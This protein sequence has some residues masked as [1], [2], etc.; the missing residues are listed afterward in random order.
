MPL[1]PALRQQF[2]LRPDITYLNF[3]SFGACPRPVFEQY[4]QF[5]LALEQ[6]PVQ[7][8][9]ETGPQYLIT[10]REALSAYIN[11]DA[12]DLVYVVNPSHAVNI[13]AKSLVLQPGDEV[14]TTSLEYGACDRTWEFYCS[15][16]GAHYVKQP[17]SLP[18]VSAEDFV[19]QFF[20]GVTS[21]T[22][23]VFL[24]HITSSTALRLP[25]EL[26]IQEAQKR[27]L[28][29]FVDGA[30]AP[31]QI[32]LDLKALG[33]DFYTG[34]CHKWMMTPKGSSFL[35][36]KKEMQSLLEPL[37]VSWGYKSDHP[38]HSA[39]LDYHQ[40]QGTRDFSAFLCIPAALAFMKENHWD[41][42]SAAC[43]ALVRENAPRF[44]ELLNT[45]P[46]APLNDQF[47][48]QLCSFKLPTTD[49]ERVKALLFNQFHIE[50]PVMRHGADVYL[51]YSIQAF[52]SQ[53]D[54]DKLY[55][56]LTAIKDQF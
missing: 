17:I 41:Q 56:A 26:I 50:I 48:L 15:K 22:K 24:S 11:V 2:L 31:G 9:T 51:R 25:V 28:L 54:L 55:Q 30:H 47:I 6:E 27:G 38:S 18:L 42:V 12:D 3:G 19:E 20:K 8:I 36:A 39:F 5:Q 29:T 45:S 23:L 16:V 46:L 33:V 49:A 7:F 13:V 21:R 40:T 14:L 37:V 32:S 52:N 1:T 44:C 4:Q 35:F 34:A 10:S 43:R 53:E